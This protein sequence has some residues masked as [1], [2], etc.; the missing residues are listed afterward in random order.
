MCVN[1]L[2]II[3]LLQCKYV[4]DHEAADPTRTQYRAI[5]TDRSTQ[6]AFLS[7][8]LK[9]PRLLVAVRTAANCARI[10]AWSRV[11]DDV[12]LTNQVC[13]L[14]TGSGIQKSRRAV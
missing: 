9:L 6:V 8:S 11:R 3:L 12:G 5:M 1:A 14:K 10:I 7:L 4:H 2:C 13:A